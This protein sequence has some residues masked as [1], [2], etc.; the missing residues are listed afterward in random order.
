MVFIFFDTKTKLKFMKDLKVKDYKTKADIKYSD[1]MEFRKSIPED[2]DIEDVDVDFLTMRIL[3]IFYIVTRLYSIMIFII[4]LPLT[5]LILIF[6]TVIKH[7]VG[8]SVM[9]DYSRLLC[10]IL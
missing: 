3:K 2:I 1:F 5:I 10:K 4:L 9:S 8:R 7:F 6:D